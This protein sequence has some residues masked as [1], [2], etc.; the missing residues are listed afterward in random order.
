MAPARFVTDSSLAQL[1]RRLRVL[2]YDVLVLPGARLEEILEAGRREGRAALTTSARH[3]RAFADV[4]TRRV[5]PERLA[6]TVREIAEASEPSSAPF[7]RCTE[8]NTPLQKRHPFEARGEVPGGILRSA[9]ALSSCPGC[10]K[11][12]WDGS[13]VARLRAWLEQA[14]GKPLGREPGAPG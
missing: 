7:R 1:A 3:P 2:G 11:W 5:R 13:H 8:C 6:E 12:Y 14:L 4:P 10:G 9:T